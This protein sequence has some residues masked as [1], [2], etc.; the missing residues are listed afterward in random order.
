MIAR[1][2]ILAMLTGNISPAV[3]AQPSAAEDYAACQVTNE[4]DFRKAVFDVTSAALVRNTA[5]I[6]FRAAVADEWRRLD[7]GRT[8]DAEVDK[9]FATVKDEQSWS[10]LLQSLGSEDKARELTTVLTERVYRSDAMTKAIEDVATGSG[11]ASLVASKLR[12]LM[13]QGRPSG[14]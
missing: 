5:S 3:A 9:A 1:A 10:S 13:P 7:V 6:D 11:A 12:L 4:A 14:A 8:L 2:V